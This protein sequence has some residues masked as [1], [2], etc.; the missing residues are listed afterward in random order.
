MAKT[1]EEE[2]KL[3]TQEQQILL[4]PD[5]V[6]GAVTEQE[7]TVWAVQNVNDLS[8]IEIRK[9]TLKYIPGFLKIFDEI[10]T[11]ASDH[12]Q[13]GG[14]VK[15]IKVTVTPEWEISVWND[16]TGIPVVKHKEHQIWLP[17]MLL[18]MLNSGSNYN[19]NDERYGAGRNGLGSGATALFSSKFQIDCADGQNR[20]QQDILENCKVRKEP[21]IKPSQKSY[22]QVTYIPDFNRLPIAG[23]E[24]A[25]LKM[26]LKRVIDIAVFNPKIKVFFNEQLIQ[27]NSIKDWCQLHLEPETELYTE[28]VDDKWSI[29]LAGSNSDQFEQ[30][31]IV[32]GNTT[33]IGGTHVDYI[34]SN[35]VK[36]LT[37]DLTKGNKGIKIRPSD[38]KSKFHLFLV[39]RIANPTFDTQTKEN[40]TIKITDKPD[41]SDKIYKQI[42][43][44]EI[45]EN[46]LNWVQMK[47]QMEL[48]KMNKKAAGKTLRIPKLVDAHKA[49][50]DDGWKASLILAEG[51]CLDEDTKIKVF[52]DDTY[53]EIFI[54]DAKIGDMIITHNGSIREIYGITKKV[55]DT[56]KINYNNTSI[57]CSKEHRFLIYDKEKN[58]FKF[59]EAQKID[60]NKH[61]FL[62][63]KI[64]NLDSLFKI[65]QIEQIK[66]SNQKYQLKIKLSNSEIESSLN[67]KFTVL[68]DQ[69]NQIK[70]I[71]A[72]DLKKDNLLVSIL[73]S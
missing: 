58:V 39:S 9:Q 12:V 21:K 27:I 26:I 53:K 13:R 38:I 47:E 52:K 22:T 69:T 15:S 6:I 41:F 24:E 51:D 17:G 72:K 50:T 56:V 7:K 57:T 33:W 66:D 61:Q 59:V 4:R 20:Y 43:K 44:S 5:T 49:G 34:M 73:P 16:G 31:S 35:V 18:G 71:E 54:K 40:L 30:C 42:L 23:L 14:G 67:H 63:S 65:H 64:Y 60:P 32:N 46:I 11:N 48:N 62:K 37:E 8:K 2:Y 10:L 28:V 1:I 36:R 29:A 68:D 55:K 45:I 19:D 70:L 3:L 25:T